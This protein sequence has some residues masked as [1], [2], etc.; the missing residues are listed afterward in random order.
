MTDISVLD[1][2]ST[3]VVIVRAIAEEDVSRVAAAGVVDV[4]VVVAHV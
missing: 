4:A 1:A 3:S 2:S